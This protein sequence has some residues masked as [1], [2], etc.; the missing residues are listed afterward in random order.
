M[1]GEEFFGVIKE[2][3]FRKFIMQ[4]KTIKMAIYSSR[5]VKLNLLIYYEMNINIYLKLE[6]IL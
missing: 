1:C 2:K 4:R 6:L 3:F 5:W